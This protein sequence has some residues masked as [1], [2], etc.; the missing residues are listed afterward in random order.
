MSDDDRRSRSTLIALIAGVVLV[1]VLIALIAVFARGGPTQFDADT[2]EGVVQRYSQAVV[3]GDI[4]DR[5]DLPRAR[6]RRLVRASAGRASKTTGSPCW[7]PRSATT[8]PRVRSSSPRCTDRVR[9]APTSTRAR[10]PSTS[11]KV[12]GDWLIERGAV[13]ARDLRR[14]GCADDSSDAPVPSGP[15]ARLPSGA[16]G[17]RRSCAASSSSSSSSRSSS[18]PPIGSERPDRARDRRRTSVLAGDDAGLALSLAF[19]LIGVPLAGRAVVVAAP[20]AHRRRR[21]AGVAGVGAVPHR[22]VA[23]R[24]SSWRPSSLASAAAAGIDG[25][26]RPGELSTG[27]VWLGRVGVA[28]AHAPQRGDG[29]RRASPMCPSSCRRCTGSPSRHPARSPRSPV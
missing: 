10:S 14:G 28:P 3:D 4:A 15:S 26:W 1:V 22:D 13:A 16:G 7:R 11:S 29:A 27:V 5:P 19:T 17:R 20:P 12:G 25:E 23:H 8:P 2:P 24:R 21:R 9:W 18:S 6:S